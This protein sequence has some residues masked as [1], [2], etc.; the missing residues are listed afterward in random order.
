MHTRVEPDVTLQ[1]SGNLVSL[2]HF[3]QKIA[4][5]SL[6]CG[7]LPLLLLNGN[8]FSANAI[9][10]FS[11]GFLSGKLLLLKFKLHLNA[12]LSLS[13]LG[14]L[15]GLLVVFFCINLSLHLRKHVFIVLLHFLPE[16]LL[17]C[18]FLI[19]LRLQLGKLLGSFSFK[20]LLFLLLALHVLLVFLLGL[21]VHR[22]LI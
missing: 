22:K 4:Q 11:L 21:F 14:L 8:G 10:A 12:H 7:K 13:V 2:V 1:L 15:L 18:F 16:F 19:L 20:R 17:L 5:L 9:L 6:K 3:G